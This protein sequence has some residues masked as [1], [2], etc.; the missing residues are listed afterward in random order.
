MNEF[1]TFQ[2]GAKVR[3]ISSSESLPTKVGRLYTVSG[4]Y[5]NPNIGLSFRFKELPEG[6]YK[7]SRFKLAQ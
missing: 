4:V 5:D 6:W 1:R 2:L 3:C 7:V